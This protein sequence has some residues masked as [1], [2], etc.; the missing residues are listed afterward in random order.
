MILDSIVLRFGPRAV[1][2]SPFW[3][4]FV[5]SGLLSRMLAP[6][7]QKSYGSVE[8]TENARAVLTVLDSTRYYVAST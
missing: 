7:S 5:F 8:K 4:F 1:R 2:E 6:F 3:S